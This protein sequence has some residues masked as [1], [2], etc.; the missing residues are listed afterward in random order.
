MNF[1][2]SIKSY[3]GKFFTSY[4]N[5]PDFQMLLLRL[6]K[7]GMLFSGVI[8]IIATTSYIIVNILFDRRTIA[9]NYEAPYPE[10]MVLW[11]K[12]LIILLSVVAIILARLKLTLGVYRILFTFIILI[13]AVAILI[14]DIFNQDLNFSS[15]YLTI[16]LLLA[17]ACIPYK[18]WQILSICIV[19]TLLLFPGLL[20]IQELFGFSG[21][22][23]PGSQIVYLV[24]ITV[25]LVG[26]TTMFYHSRYAQY[27][28]RKSA[29]GLLEASYFTG[30]AEKNQKEMD[31]ARNLIKKNA[32]D[33]F[34]QL[35]KEIDVLSMDQVFLEK[36]KTVIETHI[37]DANFGV[38]WLAHEV[39]LSPRQLQRKLRS[40]IGLSAG[41]LIRVMRMQ[42]AAQLLEKRAGNI[43]EIA[44]KVGF[45]DPVYFS[46]IF[47]QMYEVSP[48]EYSK[49]GRRD[50][51]I[52]KEKP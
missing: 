45:H 22:H 11:D 8:G 44:Y 34:Q 38:E 31:Q 3:T 9:W 48:S 12:L 30:N 28:L 19:M 29:D 1:T 41:G 37:G 26:T 39:A 18:P 25:I 2:A 5:N 46:R 7:N 40:S 36:V 10:L 24:I 16:L 51:A 33:G 27:I 43:S 17:S 35:V 21:L 49:T 50:A 6:S 20:Y 52:S 42:R 13:C 23:V 15:A 14:D 47:R 4:E 32:F